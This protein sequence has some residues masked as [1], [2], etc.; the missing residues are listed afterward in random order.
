MSLALL[1]YLSQRPYHSLVK[2]VTQDFGH[3]QSTRSRSSGTTMAES[4]QPMKS[5]ESHGIEHGKR[6]SDVI[7]KDLPR[8]NTR[9][10][11]YLFLCG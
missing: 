5:L 7:E 2:D 11:K 6:W 1:N 10:T 9:I 3:S 4:K 8:Y